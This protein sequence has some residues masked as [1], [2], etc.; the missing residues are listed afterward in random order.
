[1]LIKLHVSSTAL[2]PVI[3]EEEEE[4]EVVHVNRPLPHH[5]TRHTPR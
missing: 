2:V 4:E 5:Q 1:M 3:A